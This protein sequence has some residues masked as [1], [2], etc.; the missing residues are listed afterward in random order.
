[1]PLNVDGGV[2]FSDFPRGP[3]LGVEVN[4][5]GPPRNMLLVRGKVDLG[6]P[7]PGVLGSFEDDATVFGR[8][9]G[10]DAV[11]PAA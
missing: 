6:E 8:L 5:D 2:R 1:M 7:V 9:D 11:L 4:G 10:C 3:L